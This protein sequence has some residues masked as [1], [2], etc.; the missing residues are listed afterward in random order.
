VA[1]TDLKIKKTEEFAEWYEQLGDTLK[2]RIDARLERLKTGHAGDSRSLGEG[3]FELKWKNGLRVYF[4]Y[5]KIDGVDVILV[6]GGDKS[7][8]K[9]DIKKA[10]ALKEL[11]EA[12]SED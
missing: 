6:W 11:Y 5:T 8:Q 1:D 2:T 12:E 7:T 3:L 10:R 9:S 4:S